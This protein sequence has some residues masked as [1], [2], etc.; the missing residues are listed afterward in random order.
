MANQPPL[1]KEMRV[2]KS[3]DSSVFF[4]GFKP[5]LTDAQLYSFP[6]DKGEEEG[7]L[8]RPDGSQLFIFSGWHFG[9][10]PE[11]MEVGFLEYA[12]K[13]KKDLG[14]IS[15]DSTLQTVG[16]GKTSLFEEE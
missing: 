2:G 6:R 8:A 10:N 5:P 12:Q 13:V 15:L 9:L 14:G 1:F 4:M 11:E 7:I 3:R 16:K